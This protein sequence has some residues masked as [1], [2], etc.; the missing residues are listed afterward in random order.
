MK[1]LFYVLIYIFF[2]SL[3]I[4]PK[5]LIIKKKSFKL[6]LIIIVLIF[7]NI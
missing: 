5:W 4:Y 1:I 2:V 6:L 7:V 3:K